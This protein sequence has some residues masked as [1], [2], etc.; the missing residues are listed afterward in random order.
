MNDLK[1]QILK[2]GYKQS[3]IATQT[4]IPYQ[5]LTAYITGRRNP[6]QK[7]KEKLANILNCKIGD[8]FFAESKHNNYNVNN[9]K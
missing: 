2:S 1:K 8:I 4:G 6:S 3:Y 9:N 7:N 5:T